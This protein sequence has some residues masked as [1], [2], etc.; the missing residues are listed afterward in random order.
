MTG[1]F[2]ALIGLVIRIGLAIHRNVLLAL[3]LV[4][5]LAMML[6]LLLQSRAG[7]YS[8]GDRGQLGLRIIIR[9]RGA[10]NPPLMW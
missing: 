2:D 8:L 9:L 7:F 4:V 3:V 5:V 6:L 10:M 1:G